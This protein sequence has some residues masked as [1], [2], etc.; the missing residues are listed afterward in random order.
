M[1]SGQQ[2]YPSWQGIEGYISVDGISLQGSTNDHIL[3]FEE[4][5]N[6]TATACNRNGLTGCWLQDGY[7]L[8]LLPNPCNYTGTGLAYEE[9]NDV[10]GY[11]CTWQTGISLAQD[12]FWNVY[13]THQTS[14]TNGLL[15]GYINTGSGPRLIG[16]GWVPNYAGNLTATAELEV[17]VTGNGVNQNCPSVNQWEYYGTNGSGTSSAQYALYLS[18]DGNNWAEWTQAISQEF[19]NAPYNHYTVINANYAFKTYGS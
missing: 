3:N 7:G 12:D 16:Q 11:D 14:G 13:Y 5:K 4:L 6:F 2:Q 15:D 1:Y 8:G 19:N 18:S 17:N 10:N 9:N